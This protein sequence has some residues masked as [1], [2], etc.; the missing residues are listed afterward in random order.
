M[1]C[2]GQ[3][4]G[5]QYSDS[6]LEVTHTLKPD[7]EHLRNERESPCWD[8]SYPGS[9]SAFAHLTLHLTNIVRGLAVHRLWKGDS[10]P[11]P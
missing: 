9:C 2:N 3:S 4:V 7:E 5:G 6:E 11:S 8:C 10:S 1:R